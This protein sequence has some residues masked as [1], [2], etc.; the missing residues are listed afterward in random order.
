MF[1]ALAVPAGAFAAST[2]G[3]WSIDHTS[4]AGDNGFLDCARS[5]HPGVGSHDSTAAAVANFLSLL[6][7][8]ST[9]W[10]NLVGHGNDGLIVTGTG[11]NTPDPTKYITWWNRNTW[12][13]EVSKLRGQCQIIKLW[14]CHPGTGQEGV[15][16]LFALTEE[17]GAVCMGPTGFL[18]CAGGSFTLEANSTWQVCTPGQPKPNPIQAPSPHLL[19]YTDFMVSLREGERLVKV[20]DVEAVEILTASDRLV[21]L[22]SGTEARNFLGLIDFTNP[23]AMTGVP[24]ALPTGKIL[25]SI[26]G[27][28]KAFVIYNNRIL[29][30]TAEPTKW[31]RCSESIKNIYTSFR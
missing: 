11:Q 21:G 22:L 18:N 13:P 29:Q 12:A 3:A 20:D 16:L 2:E 27:E 31:Y 1:D 6:P 25:L 24:A 9:K 30:D 10:A 8:V 17:T 23:I 28:N 4:G 15:D 7:P 26:K 14:A 5:G 19:P